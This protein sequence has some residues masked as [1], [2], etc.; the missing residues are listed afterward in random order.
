M[1]D[2]KKTVYGV[3]A[4]FKNSGELL[5]AAEKVRDAGYKDFDCHSPFP[6]HGMDDAMRLKRSPLG[7]IVGIMAFSGL[8][9]AYLLQGWVST[10]AYPLIIAGKPYFSYQ[11]YVPVGFGLAVLF[12]A[13]SAVVGMFVLIKLPQLWHPIF[14]S[15][16]F[17]K[18]TDDCFFVSIESNDKKFEA[19]KTSA[20]LTEIGGQ[21][22]EL[23]LG[24]QE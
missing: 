11:A 9:L 13:V 22:V 1:S 12:G 23:I 7:W 24:D 2:E 10:T 15:D 16:N 21:N 19:D 20:F 4:E 18:A 3:L 5:H 6:I 14:Y 17:E 8:G